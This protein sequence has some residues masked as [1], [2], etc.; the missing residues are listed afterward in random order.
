MVCLR[1]MGV[2]IGQGVLSEGLNVT[3]SDVVELGEGPVP[4]DGLISALV[5]AGGPDVLLTG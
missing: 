1:A 4:V 5:P 3:E 2:K